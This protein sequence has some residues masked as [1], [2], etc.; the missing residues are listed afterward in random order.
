MELDRMS[1]THVETRPITAARTIKLEGGSLESRRLKVKNHGYEPTK[2]AA[3]FPSAPFQSTVSPD[4][5][6]RSKRREHI[7]D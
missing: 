4:W 3:A 2:E 1:D 5:T 7:R 6:N